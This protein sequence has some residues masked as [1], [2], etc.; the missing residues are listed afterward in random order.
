MN[1]YADIDNDSNVDSYEIYETSIQ[2]WFNGTPNPYTYSYTSA[3]QHHVEAM[4]QLAACGDG[5]NAYI[6][7][8][9]KFK[10]VR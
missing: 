2:V 1:K 10:Y 6:N 5:L 9:V 3:G 4:K 7:N 8:N